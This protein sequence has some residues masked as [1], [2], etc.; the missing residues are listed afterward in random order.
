MFL[1]DTFATDED[2]TSDELDSDSEGE[3]EDDRLTTPRPANNRPP[4]HPAPPPPPWGGHGPG[5]RTP[6]GGRSN[7]TARQPTGVPKWRPFLDLKT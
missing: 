3:D 1:P 4:P 7:G 5:L 2:V 6:L